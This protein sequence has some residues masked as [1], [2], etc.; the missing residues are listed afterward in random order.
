LAP[1]T[2]IE[3]HIIR[4]IFEEPPPQGAFSVTGFAAKAFSAIYAGMAKALK[5]TTC[6]NILQNPI[7]SVP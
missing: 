6:D 7:F 4:E 3:G 2:G 1:A 5:L